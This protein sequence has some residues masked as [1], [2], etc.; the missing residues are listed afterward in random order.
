MAKFERTVTGIEAQ[1]CPRCI[2]LT[3]ELVAVK[4]EAYETFKRETAA[5]ARAEQAEETITRVKEWAL[6]NLPSGA[7]GAVLAVL[8]GDED[9]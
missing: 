8:E 2:E 6:G 1:V 4:H 9:S 3:T 5:I 7:C